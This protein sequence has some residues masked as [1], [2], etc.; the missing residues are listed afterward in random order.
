MLSLVG[1]DGWRGRSIARHL[2]SI[3]AVRPSDDLRRESVTNVMGSQNSVWSPDPRSNL[4][5]EDPNT[6]FEDTS[7]ADLLLEECP[8]HDKHNLVFGC[9]KH[10]GCP[11]VGSRR[12]WLETSPAPL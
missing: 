7:W 9:P 1:T 12:R 8:E 5:I 6:V 2:W 4:L 10:E 11:I 3:H